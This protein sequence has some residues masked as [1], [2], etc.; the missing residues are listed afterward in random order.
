VSRFWRCN[1]TVTTSEV[2]VMQFTQGVTT[3]YPRSSL[4]VGNRR[5]DRPL[6]SQD[7]ALVL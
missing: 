3:Q 7:A 1:Q 6:L 2:E 5:P 4:T